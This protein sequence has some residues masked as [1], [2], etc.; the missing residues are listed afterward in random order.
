MAEW[1]AAPVDMLSPK[2]AIVPPF[3]VKDPSKD[4]KSTKN[5]GLKLASNLP[6]QNQ[7]LK[8]G[9]DYITDIHSM[10]IFFSGGARAQTEKMS[11]KT[12]HSSV[13]LILANGL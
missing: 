10:V 9:Q 1:A 6:R 11:G 4:P 2:K 3:A 8:Q 12:I 13:R 7:T 5:A